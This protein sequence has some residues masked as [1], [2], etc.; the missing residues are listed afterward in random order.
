MIKHIMVDTSCTSVLSGAL[1]TKQKSKLT[2]GVLP[3]L[4]MPVLRCASSLA[5]QLMQAGHHA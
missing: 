4:A 2:V 1:F 5:R 3:L